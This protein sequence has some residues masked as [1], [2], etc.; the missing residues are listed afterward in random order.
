MPD[1]DG[2]SW[3]RV[4]GEVQKIAPVFHRLLKHVC[5]VG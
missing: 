5:Y 1:F 3:Q 4:D 2:F